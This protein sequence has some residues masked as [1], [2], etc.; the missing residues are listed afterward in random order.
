MH[1]HFFCRYAI[2]KLRG[3]YYDLHW[4]SF[5]SSALANAQTAANAGDSAWPCTSAWNV[6]LPPEPAQRS[7]DEDPRGERE[8][9]RKRR[10]IARDEV[11][12]SEADDSADEF[13]GGDEAGSDD[14]EIDELAGDED[15]DPT[16]LTEPRTPYQV[17]SAMV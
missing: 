8:G 2:N 15:D 16:Q 3:L 11:E 7:K 10:R 14:E 12:E 13:R 6:E 9:P 17:A 4:D 1:D 5:R